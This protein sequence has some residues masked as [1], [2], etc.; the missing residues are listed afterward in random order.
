MGR[1]AALL[2]SSIL[3]LGTIRTSHAQPRDPEEALS[4]AAGR[5][6]EAFQRHAPGGTLAVVPFRDR[7]AKVACE[8]LS[9]H[10]TDLLRDALFA[11]RNER[12]H[13]FAIAVAGRPGAAA[14][15][16]H[17]SWSPGD[18]GRLALSLPT[19]DRRTRPSRLIDSPAAPEVTTAG[20]PEAARDCLLPYDPVDRPARVSGTHWL[21][22]GPFL[23]A[24]RRTSLAD[25][26]E[27]WVAARM[28]GRHQRPWSIVEVWRDG[29]R[30]RGFVYG[31]EVAWDDEGPPRP[32]TALVVAEPAE[33]T[34]R[35]AL[36][37]DHPASREA[38]AVVGT[39]LGGAGAQVY[40]SDGID[41]PDGVP[42]AGPNWLGR[43]LG[44]VRGARLGGRSLGIRKL[45]TVTVSGRIGTGGLGMRPLRIGLVLRAFDVASGRRLAA[46]REP[47][48]GN[49]FFVPARCA[50]DVDCVREKAVRRTRD[51]AGRAGNTLASRLLSAGVAEQYAVELRGFCEVDAREI[52][53]HMRGVFPGGR[54]LALEGAAAD[55]TRRYTYW[56]RFGAA[57][58]GH[59]LGRA[60][61]ELGLDGRVLLEGAVVTVRAGEVC[62]ES[63]GA[64]GMQ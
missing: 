56:G 31:L 62:P 38:V 7:R 2:L 18:D 64:G 58:L 47:A 63:S 52:E 60:L 59:Y 34:D 45:V 19:A 35:A 10:L 9:S 36:G 57:R 15:E 24:G 14:G 61:D 42:A 3:A 13:D 23:D 49:G 41:I 55:G 53:R 33:P 46:L 4:V 5:I 29:F 22:E 27:V 6:V 43:L 50:R 51:L 1:F 8:P 20:L 25:G 30:E 16:I 17:G 21:R 54:G 28:R 48:G 11:A 12:G 32:V 40:A 44:A 39:A 37:P 26:E